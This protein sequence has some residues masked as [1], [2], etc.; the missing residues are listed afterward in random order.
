MKKNIMISL[1]Y[2]A[3]T[4]YNPGPISVC[5]VEFTQPNQITSNK[6]LDKKMWKLNGHFNNTRIKKSFFFS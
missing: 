6:S 3:N 5:T 4:I 2:L 1:N